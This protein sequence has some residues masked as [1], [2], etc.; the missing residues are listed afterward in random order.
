[1]CML[2]IIV[3]HRFNRASLLNAGFL[4]SRDVCDYMVMHDV[5]L[6]PL[7]D[8]LKYMYPSDGPY[9]ISSPSLHPL[10]HYKTFVG[11]ILSLTREQFETVRVNIHVDYQNVMTLYFSSLAIMSID[12]FTNLQ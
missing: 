10:Y 7:N 4:L 9:H 11:G 5:D 12:C 8:D 6:L 1:M 3:S 2:I